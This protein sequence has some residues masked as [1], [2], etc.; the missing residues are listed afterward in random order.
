MI[1]VDDFKIIF[2]CVCEK[3]I[4]FLKIFALVV[5]VSFYVTLL[6]IAV[7]VFF[8]LRINSRIM[9]GSMPSFDYELLII[10]WYLRCQNVYNCFVYVQICWIY[11]ITCC[12]IILLLQK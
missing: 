12:T 3:V 1:F 2:I 10:T 4:F 7:F 5:L 9:Y 8:K 11:F 6:L